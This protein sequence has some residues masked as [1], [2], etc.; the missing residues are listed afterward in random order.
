[1]SFLSLP[2]DPVGEGLGHFFGAMRIDAFRPAG[3]FKSHM[4]R[5]IERFRNA[6]TVEGHDRV[7]IPG[8]PERESELE[9]TKN[10]IPLHESVYA[11][12][13]EVAAR[14]SLDF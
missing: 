8:D 11:D 12:L 4:D 1:V 2:E 3:E 9:R 6:K 5:W 10:G 13:K 7:I 14:F